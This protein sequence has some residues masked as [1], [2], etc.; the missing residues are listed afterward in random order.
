MGSVPA[1][2][3]TYAQYYDA[4]YKDKDYSE[5]ARYLHNLLKEH[6]A[7]CKLLEFGSGTGR[8]A[9]HLIRFGYHI[10]GVERSEAMI[11]LAVQSDS[12]QCIAGDIRYI[13]L[14]RMFSAVVAFFHVVSYQTSD[15]DL[16]Q[17]FERAAAH[18]SSG[19]LFIF[20]FWYSPAVLSQGAQLR[21][22]HLS[23]SVA[24]ITRIAEPTVYLDQHVVDVKYTMFAEIRDERRIEKITEVHRMRHFTLPELIDVAKKSGFEFVA[25]EE[26]VTRSK[27]SKLTWGVC[28]VVRKA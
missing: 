12:F 1:M 24:D 27:P 6:G 4:L 13:Q 15:S 21:V 14:G 7:G 20:D 26:P 9:R 28:M 23:T 17:T 2:F 5:E 8:H 22:K 11:A 10:F 18:L 3:D 19:G 25:A 16:Q